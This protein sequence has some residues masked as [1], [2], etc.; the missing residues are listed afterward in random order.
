MVTK[1][2]GFGFVLGPLE[3]EVMEDL[4]ARGGWVTVS[5]VMAERERR[6]NELAYSTIKAV[7][8]NLHNKG[9]LKKRPDGKQNVFTP[10]LAREEFARR[11]V[12]RVVDPLLRHHRNP[13]LAHII[14]E[15]IDDE[16]A[17]AEFETLLAAKRVRPP[18]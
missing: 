17:I 5:E 14:D 2:A 11:A 7:M 18:R 16:E 6:G 12:S 4:W 9:H 13:L 8:Q 15:L 1:S 3:S 10:V